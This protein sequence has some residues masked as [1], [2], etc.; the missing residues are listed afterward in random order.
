MNN[1]V[2]DELDLIDVPAATVAPAATTTTATAPAAVPSN[3]ESWDADDADDVSKGVL[4]G[5]GVPY[6]KVA[7]NQPVRIALVPNSKIVGAAVHYS[8]ASSKYFI[9]A[10]TPGKR[11]ACCDKLGDAKGRAAALCF[12]YKNA[13]PQSAKLAPGTAP[14]VEIGIFTMSRSNYADLKNGVEE[15]QSV[16]DVDFRISVTPGQLTRKVAVISRVARWREIEAEALAL[17]APFLADPGQLTKALGR[18][19][20]ATASMDAMLA[21]IETL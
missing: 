9:C 10:S 1:I 5:S 14:V 18:K 6:V 20:E 12:V 7:E 11:S 2:N 4:K 8:Q 16:T 17:A 19:F 13:D 15:G 21:D 3:I